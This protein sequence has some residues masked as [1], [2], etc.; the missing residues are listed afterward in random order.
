MEAQIKRTSSLTVK[1]KQ[2]IADNKQL[3]EVKSKARKDTP[4]VMPR[5]STMHEDFSANQSNSIMMTSMNN[6][7]VAMVNIPE[8]KPAENE[9]EIDRKSFEAWKNLLEASMD[10]VGITDENTKMNVFKVKA[11]L[12]LLEVLE[13]TPKQ[14]SPDG[15][16]T[17]YSNAMVRLK[18]FFGSR[19]H[20]NRQRL[21]LSAMVQV[22]GEPDSKYVKRIITAAK[23]C[24]FD[25]AKLT[26]R[27]AEVLQLHAL[28]IKVREAGSK[29]IRKGGSLTELIDKIRGY[30]LNKANEEIFA[31]NHP[32]A[33]DAMVAA[34][35]HGQARPNYQR[36]NYQG[37]QPN[38][39]RGRNIAPPP[40]AANWQGFRGASS[41]RHRNVARAGPSGILCWRCT[42]RNHLPTNCHAKE[43]ICRNCQGVG[44]IERAC[45]K[46]PTPVAPKRRASEDDDNSPK[47][48]KIALV[49]K[50]EDENED[51]NTVSDYST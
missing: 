20:G 32:P 33:A 7:S 30:E 21:R 6:L 17:P 27:V 46:M 24:D 29:L 50:E 2:V 26:E 49:S 39:L 11:G 12:K 3:R 8:C 10:L 38:G 4:D 18:E 5:H 22:Q 37:G 42:S 35:T 41:D 31:K 19:E 1:L 15:D 25:D 23:L 48:K 47:P 14:N 44:H 45:R 43:K 13:G 51:P 40:R 28:N 36:W 9:D 34:V 16:N